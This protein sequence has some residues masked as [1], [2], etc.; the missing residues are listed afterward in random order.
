VNK[1][2]VVHPCD[3][4]E[5]RNNIDG[6]CR[7]VMNIMLEKGVLKVSYGYLYHTRELLYVLH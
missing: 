1:L 5:G 3:S 7:D 2:F 4:R 6:F